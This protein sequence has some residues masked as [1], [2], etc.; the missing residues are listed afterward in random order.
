MPG[1]NLITAEQNRERIT[2]G[3]DF[4]NFQESTESNPFEFVTVK[5]SNRQ[6]TEVSL[7]LSDPIVELH[8]VDGVID[9]CAW[10]KEDLEHMVEVYHIIY[11]EQD[12]QWHPCTNVNDL[13]WSTYD[14]CYYFLEDCIFGFL[15]DGNEGYF[16]DRS[17]YIYCEEN[18]SYYYD[19][20]V[21]S[22][23][24]VNYCECIDDYAVTCDCDDDEDRGYHFDN[25]KSLSHDQ[26]F[27]RKNG[28]DSPT[29]TMTNGMQYTFG[30][31]METSSS[32]LEWADFNFKAV[33]DGS[34]E[35]PEYV[36]GVLKGDYGFKHLKA[37]CTKLSEEAYINSSC[38]VHVHIGGVFNRRFT[39]MLLRLGYMI[40]D[41]VF[42]MM[43][44][45]RAG[46]SFCKYIPTWAGELI[47]FQNWKKLVAKYIYGEDT[48]LSQQYN[49]KTN[50]DRYS[51]TRYRWVNINNYS[52]G[53]N[54]PTVEFRCHGASLNYEK[55]RNW[56]L[57][58]MCIVRYAENN[59]RE[60]WLKEDVNLK[61]VIY[62]GL[63]ENLGKQVYDY[64]EQRVEK[65][66]DSYGSRNL[67]SDITREGNAIR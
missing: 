22:E 67:P 38:G 42:R 43:P 34:T 36:T 4:T 30:V 33:Y 17:Q 8:T 62:A 59:Q 45:S 24:G 57:I 37:I 48:E 50:I 1:E 16:S 27:N 49:K 10:K 15:P 44:P 58:C 60:I 39:I 12:D 18:D 11:L 5:L 56:V 47:N 64:Y 55:I 26:T 6:N 63:G 21:A 61:K 23:H 46:N 25:I 51:S 54:R 41:E 66:K 52:T 19:D 3:L 29:H 13:R 20:D 31:E 32:R 35:G 65:F 53:T 28:M 40:Q 2:D 9:G 14:L 7:P